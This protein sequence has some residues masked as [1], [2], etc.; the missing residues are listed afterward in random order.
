MAQTVDWDQTELGAEFAT[1]QMKREIVAGR[2]DLFRDLFD[3][4][5]S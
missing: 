5:L 1:G 3:N 2:L 4:V